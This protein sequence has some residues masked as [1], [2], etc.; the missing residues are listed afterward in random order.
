VASEETV[1]AS[2]MQVPR[3]FISHSHK[4][5]LIVERLAEEIEASG[6]SCWLDLWEMEVGDSIRRRVEEGIKTADWLL[7]VLSKASVKSQWVVQ[8]I[9]MAFVQEL[10]KRHAFV[11]PVVL[12]PCEIPLSLRDK[13]YADFTAD[14]NTGLQTLLKRFQS[15]PPEQ[16]K[17][18]RK[19]RRYCAECDEQLPLL[20]LLLATVIDAGLP[21]AQGM[22]VLSQN[23]PKPIAQEILIWL[24]DFQTIDWKLNSSGDPS[25]Q[26]MLER[27]PTHR[28]QL[29]AGMWNI[30]MATG[31]LDS[32]LKKVAFEH[33]EVGRML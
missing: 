30:G 13:L 1:L 12:E 23:M 3:I 20:A 2:E 21:L 4:D 28:M 8:E 11:L 26:R 19:F 16:R 17:A 27:V 33:I 22:E 9:D 15:L 24:K 18:L 14:F 10:E 5:N 25:V 29:F 31:Q 32:L 7:V 6:F